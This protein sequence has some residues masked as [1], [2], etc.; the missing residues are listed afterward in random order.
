MERKSMERAGREAALEREWAGNVFA[1]LE[2]LEENGGATF[3]AW[4]MSGQATER[5]HGVTLRF[6]VCVELVPA[7]LA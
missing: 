4:A 5:G 2:Q 7:R 6:D 1:G 3:G